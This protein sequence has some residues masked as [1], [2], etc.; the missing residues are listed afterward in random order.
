MYVAAMYPRIAV[1]LIDQ[2][3][4]SSLYDILNAIQADQKHFPKVDVT[5]SAEKPL[6]TP[7]I[8]TLPL[9]G[10]RLRFAPKTQYLCLIEIIDL[11]LDN[12]TYKGEPLV[13]KTSNVP[14]GLQY[15]RVYHLFG[16]S[17]PGEYQK[18]P[19][20]DAEGLYCLSFQGIALSFPM[21]TS[22]WIP[23]TDHAK[24]LST[25]A[26][27]VSSVAIYIGGSWPDARSHLSNRG[28]GE[29]TKHHHHDFDHAIIHAD[30]SVELVNTSTQ[31]VSLCLG[32]S[33][34]QDL[35]TDL[36]PPDVVYKRP[37]HILNPPRANDSTD[38]RR[39]SIR[40][41]SRASA[42]SSFSSNNTDSYDFDF[43]ENSAVE[44]PDVT[45]LE[46]QYYCYY[47]HGI[48]ILL[49]DIGNSRNHASGAPQVVTRVILH[50]NIP[51]SHAFGRHRRIPWNF[52]LNEKQSE[53]VTSE[54]AF[55]D[56]QSALIQRFSTSWPERDMKDGMVIVRDWNADTL[57]GSA[58]LVEND[59]DVEENNTDADKADQWLKN[60][61]LFRFP[62]LMF[63]VMHNGAISALTVC[64]TPQVQ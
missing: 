6:T 34:A 46:E 52:A 61:Q 44:G 53:P 36:G 20:N 51:G 43:D 63:E 21:Q 59:S 57:G 10:I 7:V 48:D 35:V 2:A 55:S 8:V 47:R 17:Y 54:S 26:G 58:I 64:H 24:L 45:K 13:P 19:G 40:R 23:G 5:F 28:L 18:L 14:S 12:F 25:A 29:S 4:G 3:L 38:R 50:G 9:N 49:G 39:S 37:G 16:P 42:P 31:S 60:T 11:G 15:R 30:E 33:T 62:G 22:A 41:H 1:K 56:V 32:Q 27:P